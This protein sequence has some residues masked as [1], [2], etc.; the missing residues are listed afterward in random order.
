MVLV[1]KIFHW[2]NGRRERVLYESM[3]AEFTLANYKY[4]IQMDAVD[5]KV[6]WLS[7]EGSETFSC[8]TY[9]DNGKGKLFLMEEGRID[10]DKMANLI[11]DRLDE[12]KGLMLP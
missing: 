7:G 2:P 5:Y 9:D 10:K 6:Y 8:A 1:E 3:S 11:R 12:W 4:S